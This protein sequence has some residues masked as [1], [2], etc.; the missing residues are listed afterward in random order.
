MDSS[1]ERTPY[2]FAQDLAKISSHPHPTI[3][4][5]PSSERFNRTIELARHSLETA[6]I[7]MNA[8]P[9]HDPREHPRELVS[10]KKEQQYVR[11]IR[12]LEDHVRY[13][14]NK[15]ISVYVREDVPP[16]PESRT[17]SPTCD[18]DED[19]AFLTP[20]TSKRCCLPARESGSVEF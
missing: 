10:V 19:R 1:R 12:K 8:L 15:A 6:I 18:S 9:A 20:L 14:W 16:T 2:Q 7:A 17:P 4:S 5:C 11:R 13:A 3:H